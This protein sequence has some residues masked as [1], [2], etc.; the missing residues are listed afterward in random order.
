MQRGLQG[1][2]IPEGLYYAG[3]VSL[4]RSVELEGGL[5]D[6][7][8]GVDDGGPAAWWHHETRGL[9]VHICRVLMVVVVAADIAEQ[10]IVDCETRKQNIK[11]SVPCKPKSKM[12]KA[13]RSEAV[14]A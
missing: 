5:D 8:G 10:R 3:K 1:D 9:R 14:R 13:R 6:L 11:E 4:M 7:G 2:V 12:R